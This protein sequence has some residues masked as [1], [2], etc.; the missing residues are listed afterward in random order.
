MFSLFMAA[1]NKPLIVDARGVKIDVSFTKK[2]E[3]FEK[4]G[5]CIG[6]GGLFFLS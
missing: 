2:G 5:D 3:F 1:M 6:R 4:V